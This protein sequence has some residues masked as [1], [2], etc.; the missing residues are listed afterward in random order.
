MQGGP[1]ERQGGVY[2]FGGKSRVANWTVSHVFLVVGG[3]ALFCCLVTVRDMVMLQR[4]LMA[5]ALFFVP[6]IF[7]R[8][9]WR[10]RCYRTEI[11]TGT[12]KIRFFRFYSKEVV[13]APVR[14]VEFRCDRTELVCLYAGVKF[15]IFLEY[16]DPI[17]ELLP[18]G[19]EIKFS[20]G[21]SGRFAKR[22]FEKRRRARNENHTGRQPG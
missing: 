11:D 21:S 9:L 17:T 12:E 13:E 18:Q 19:V 14:S 15:T 4:A 8:L 5:S 1:Q 10:D 22:Q 2:V 3:I 6:A 7:I 20:E 16:M